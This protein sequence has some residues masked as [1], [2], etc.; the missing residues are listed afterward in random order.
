MKKRTYAA[1]ASLLGAGMILSACGFGQS[2]DSQQPKPHSGSDHVKQ[3][4]SGDLQEKTAS[5]DK[6]PAFLSQASAEVKSG[7]VT[8]ASVSDILSSIPCY[9]G[10]GESAGHKSNLNCFI[11]EINKDGSVLWDDHGT[12][13]G[14]CLETA[15]TTAEMKKQ[16]KSLKEIRRIIDEQYKEGYAP[17]TPTP[18]PL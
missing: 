17:P 4:A 2:A 1:L 11:S 10:C 14:V 8:A 7:Y 12:R 3:T 13:C 9:C 15:K 18:M 6:L 16:G 5:L